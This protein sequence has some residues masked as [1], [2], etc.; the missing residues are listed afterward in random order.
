MFSLSEISS[1]V[2]AHVANEKFVHALLPSLRITGIAPLKEA[3]SGD[4]AFFFSKNFQDD[5]FVTQASVVITGTAFVSALEASGLPQWKSTVFLACDEP[6][7]AMALVSAQFSKKLSVHDHQEMPTQSRIHATAVIDPSV[8]LGKNVTIQ[9]HAVIEANGI[10]G[11]GVV[12]YPH[13]YVGPHCEIGESSVLFPSVTLYE[14]TIIGKR[15]RLHSGVVIGADGFGYAQKIDL[16]TQHP[17]D[18]LKI[19]HL[20]RVIIE[21]DVEIGAN[22]SV[23]R[24]TLGNTRIHSKVKIDNIVQI[25][26]NCEVGEGSILCGMAGMAGSSTLGKFVVIGA[27]SGTGNQVTMGDYSKMG[28]YSGGA[29]DVPPGVE[30]SGMPARPMGEHYKILALQSKM[31]REHRKK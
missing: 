1:L 14:N 19:Y 7:L 4:I 3:R 30:V 26:H 20:G 5:L 24:G 2:K 13:C 29:K 11:D 12:I 31:L 9:A 16:T 15:C 6:Y 25:G 27:R 22:S 21:D 8:K 10:I 17:V 23:D 18:H 28:A